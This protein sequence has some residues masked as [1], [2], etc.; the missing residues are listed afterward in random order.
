MIDRPSSLTSPSGSTKLHQL[1]RE[2]DACDVLRLL[3]E[4]NFKSTTELEQATGLTRS[5]VSAAVT[6]LKSKGLIEPQ[7][8]Q[9]RKSD[10]NSRPSPHDAAGGHVVGIDIGGSN[11]RVALADMNGTLLGR[12]STS[13]KRKSSPDLVIEQVQTGVTYLLR[14]ASVPSCSLLAVAAGAPGITNRDA[15]VVI[16]TSYLKGWKNIPLRSL[17][18]SAF[19]VPAV[20]ENDVRLG[21]IGEHWQGAARGVRNFV[22]LAIGTGIAMGTFVNGQLVHGADWA[23]GEV[24]YMLVP[25]T[26]ETPLRRGEPG[27]LES[28]I[29]GEG[30]KSQWLHS[31]NGRGSS[32][33][34]N[35]TATEIFERAQTGDP[36]AKSVL[37]R[38]ARLLA[39][40]VY[41]ISLVLNSSL[42]V[43][44]GGVGVNKP[45]RDATQ[46]IL[47][48]YTSPV[49]PKL[50]LSGLRQDA[51]LMGT[52]RLAL[53]KAESGL[54]LTESGRADYRLAKEQMRFDL[55]PGR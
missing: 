33:P 45:L 20:V 28:V 13:T 15:G 23:A 52:I 10:C 16:A 46:R 7:T 55:P 44:G 19:G 11:L 48:Q 26:P 54:G 24:G 22:F 29:A 14:Q 9:R 34:S 38:T 18:E 43:L 32:F 25:G 37:D 50:V 12:W 5:R 21:A 35:L 8:N 40:A 2:S 17:L 30:I 51:Q 36:L 31:R 53:D 27:A 4:R 6:L 3:Q 39:S 1:F 42:F 47:K 41:N 49:P